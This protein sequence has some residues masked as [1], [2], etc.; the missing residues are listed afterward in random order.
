[1]DE[2][3]ERRVSGDAEEEGAGECAVRD[4]VSIL[5]LLCCCCCS[6]RTRSLSPSICACVN[7][8]LIP[9]SVRAALFS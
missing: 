5:A 1:V 8:L 4:V 6:S 2:E 9:V 3:E 7:A